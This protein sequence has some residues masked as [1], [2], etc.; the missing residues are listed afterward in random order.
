MA[1]NALKSTYYPKTKNCIV[2]LLS[3]FKKL[4]ETRTIAITLRYTLLCTLAALHV[5]M[6]EAFL[7]FDDG[8][9]EE[10]LW[11]FLHSLRYHL[12]S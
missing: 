6:R 1:L 3:F 9:V 12:V 4:T 7:K 11:Y 2:A 8:S 5:E 10:V